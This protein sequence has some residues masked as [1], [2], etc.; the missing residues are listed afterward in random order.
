MCGSSRDKA[1][2]I[3]ADNRRVIALFDQG[4]IYSLLGTGTM[5][6]SVPVCPQTI[7]SIVYTCRISY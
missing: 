6:Q 2:V 3:F 1:A 7:A 4:H 5:T